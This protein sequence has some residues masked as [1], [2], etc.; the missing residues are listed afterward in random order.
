MAALTACAVLSSGC[1]RSVD[2]VQLPGVY[3]NDATGGQ[4]QLSSDRTFSASDVSTGYS[5]GPA[6]FSGRWEFLDNEANSDFIYLSIDDGGGLGK[7]GGIQLYMGDEG[8]VY[9]RSDPDG[10]PSLVLTRTPAP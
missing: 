6:D 9:F 4:I 8:A 3:R 2:P 7:I 1:A 10:P 5:D